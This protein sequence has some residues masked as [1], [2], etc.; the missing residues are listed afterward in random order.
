M[1]KQNKRTFT[2]KELSAILGVTP[3][4]LSSWSES[5]YVTKHSRGKYD[6]V[7][8]FQH[9]VK[10]T[11]EGR[12]SNRE[13]GGNA[14]DNFLEAK[15]TAKRAQVRLSKMNVKIQKIQMIPKSLLE[16]ALADVVVTF[17]SQ[18]LQLALSSP[19][20]VNGRTEEMLREVL[21]DMVNNIFEEQLKDRLSIKK[22]ISEAYDVLF[23]K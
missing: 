5:G 12:V 17:R 11:V 6:P 20:I 2:V 9:C 15:L 10:R 7:E 22:L 1:K 8:A 21:T 16:N 23:N 13:G 3:R 14:G 18:I 19:E 4:A